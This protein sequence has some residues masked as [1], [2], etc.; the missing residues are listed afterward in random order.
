MVAVESGEYS[1]L[2]S[3]LPHLIQLNLSSLS[4]FST[5]PKASLSQKTDFILT[6]G[7]DG[8]IL[9]VSSLFDQDA[10]PP[11]LSFS[12]GTLGFLL[13]YGESRAFCSPTPTL[14]PSLGAWGLVQELI[15]SNLSCPFNTKQTSNRIELPCEIFYLRKSLCY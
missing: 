7:G 12:M 11:V 6:L 4:S 5:A 15:D 8:T 14:P 2:L 10:V 13:P 9:H 1:S 3:F